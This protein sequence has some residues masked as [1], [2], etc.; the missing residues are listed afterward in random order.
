MR[1][2]RWAITAAALAALMLLV[3][4][5]DESIGVA[6]PETGDAATSSATQTTL[7][8]PGRGHCCRLHRPL[9]GAG[10]WQSSKVGLR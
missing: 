2:K 4:V 9:A 8:T 5:R 6:A 1:V 7:S 3:S 10:C